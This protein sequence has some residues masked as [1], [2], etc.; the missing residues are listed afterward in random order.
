LTELAPG[1]ANTSVLW[2][3]KV[4]STSMVAGSEAR[5]AAAVRRMAQGG[6]LERVLGDALGQLHRGAEQVP[7]QV[8]QACGCC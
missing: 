1:S 6:E 7:M 4:T 5:D 2:F 8:A 3:G